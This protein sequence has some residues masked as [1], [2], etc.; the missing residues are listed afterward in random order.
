[1]GL[2]NWFFGIGRPY[3]KYKNKSITIHICALQALTCEKI[4]SYLTQ[5]YTV[6][7]STQLSSLTTISPSPNVFIL[8]QT[9]QRALEGSDLRNQ[10]AFL[11]NAH[12]NAKIIYCDIQ[13][14]AQVCA[15][16]GVDAFH[17]IES[18]YFGQGSH[19]VIS[20]LGQR[21]PDTNGHTGFGYIDKKL[22][23][24][25]IHSLTK[26]V[27]SDLQE[28]GVTD[29]TS[30][31]NE[32]RTFYNGVKDIFTVRSLETANISSELAFLEKNMDKRG[33]LL[34]I[35][36]GNG[37]LT[38]PL[39]KK[40]KN[41]P[42]TIIGIDISDELLSQANLKSSQ[43]K[44]QITFLQKNALRTEFPDKYADTIIIM[45][46]T[47]C[48][49]REYRTQLFG[50]M[51]RILKP[52]GK[53][54]FDFPDMYKN[55]NISQSGVYRHETPFGL[56]ISLVPELSDVFTELSSKG[57]L[58]IQYERVNWGV[59]KFVIVARPYGFI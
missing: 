31:E 59:P 34:D 22:L 40:F 48:D 51:C 50:E 16:A 41:K 10:L 24:E 42:L 14:A 56:Y 54:I 21:S 11:K 29:I 4:A 37:R 33:I 35:G 20:G 52:G 36:C 17:S 13:H 30:L 9:H 38:I 7:Y 19:D 15:S 27:N 1:M 53:L 25:Q 2:L 3:A 57:L 46:H 18:Y 26:T 49:L 55:P 6:S 58:D 5:Y 8:F 44:L 43:E 39:A 45:W 12:P 47:V 23:L 32:K 28:K